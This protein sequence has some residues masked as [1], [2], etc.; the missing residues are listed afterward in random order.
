MIKYSLTLI[1]AFILVSQIKGQ[2]IQFI[3]LKFRHT[4]RIPYN[5]V[6]IKAMTMN[7]KY[8]LTVKVDL[9]NNDENWSKSKIDTAY[10]LTSSEFNKLVT[11]VTS[12]STTDIIKSMNGWGEDGTYWYLS[13]GDFQSKVSYDLWTI[14]YKTKERGLEKYVDICEY[15]LSLGRLS[16]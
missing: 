14:D 7:N 3:E 11:M 12:I 9:I 16:Y 8:I 4:L 5:N 1:F 2:G 6:D 10:V 13:Y 15:I